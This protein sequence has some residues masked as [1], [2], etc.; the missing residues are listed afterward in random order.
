MIHR[1]SSKKSAYSHNH[2]YDLLQRKDTTKNQQREKVYG[3]NP[4][5][6]QGQ[7][8]NGLFPVESKKDALNCPSNEL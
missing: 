7:A 3:M 1:D 2:S 8:S 4:G 6:N 5:G